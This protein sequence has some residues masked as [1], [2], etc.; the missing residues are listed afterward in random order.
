MFEEQL[1]RLKAI[2][3]EMAAYA[4]EYSHHTD[5]SAIA[6]MDAHIDSLVRE[7]GALMGL[8]KEDMDRIDMESEAAVEAQIKAEVDQT[9][10]SINQM[11]NRAPRR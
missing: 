7:Q 10:V 11:R 1:K 3:A 2:S 6:A 8:S 4:K 5:Q 9:V